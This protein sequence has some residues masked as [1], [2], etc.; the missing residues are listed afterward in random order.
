M[1]TTDG[2]NLLYRLIKDNLLKAQIVLSV[3][4]TIDVPI[5]RTELSGNSIKIYAYVDEDAIGQITK[6]RLI[7]VDGKNFLERGENLS[8]DD[9]G[10][11]VL[12]E[13]QLQEV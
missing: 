10:L 3:G 7:S 9:R 5:D 6:Y 4:T 1:I 8:K 13:I 2:T 12:F 11:L